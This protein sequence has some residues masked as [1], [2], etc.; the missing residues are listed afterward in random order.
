MF[1]FSNEDPLGYI[2]P[3][4]LQCLNLSVSTLGSTDLSK[5]IMFEIISISFGRMVQFYLTL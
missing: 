3:V 2:G 5:D 1:E 4:I